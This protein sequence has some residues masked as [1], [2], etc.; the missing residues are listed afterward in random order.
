[1]IGRTYAMLYMATEAVT[2]E[3]IADVLRVI[4]ASACT[5][6]RQLASWQAVLQIWVAGNRRDWYEAE[7]DFRVILKEGLMPGVRK[8]LQTAGSQIGRTLEGVA[9]GT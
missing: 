3:E 9:A 1:M 8:K 2:L 4:K 5:L 7:T 6:L